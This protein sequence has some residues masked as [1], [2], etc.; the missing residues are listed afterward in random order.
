METFFSLCIYISILWILGY[1]KKKKK[2]IK[3]LVV[4]KLVTGWSP[5]RGGGH[6]EAD[7]RRDPTMGR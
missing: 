3:N 1:W 7:G 4:T 2:E 5:E 6:R